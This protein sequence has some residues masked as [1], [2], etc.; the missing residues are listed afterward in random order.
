MTD[1]LSRERRSE[2]MRRIRSVG[3]ALAA[4]NL[5]TIGREV[6][7]HPE[8]KF[9]GLL[10]HVPAAFC[11]DLQYRHRR[12]KAEVFVFLDKRWWAL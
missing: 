4:W 7:E 3:G 11:R 1:H 9:P 6:D 12:P 8:N 5:Q 10:V 2:Y